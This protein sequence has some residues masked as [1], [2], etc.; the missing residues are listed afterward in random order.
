MLG[1][2][3]APACPA[4][5]CP[6]QPHH[7]EALPPAC[8]HT[9]CIRRSRRSLRQARQPLRE[10]V[11]RSIRQ[12]TLRDNGKPG[13]TR[14]RKAT[15]L[16]RRPATWQPGCR[17]EGVSLPELRLRRR[18]A[19]CTDGVPGQRA[20]DDA[21]HPTQAPRHP[22]QRLGAGRPTTGGWGEVSVRVRLAL[23]FLAVSLLIPL[24]GV[25]AV[26][27]QY[28]ASQRAATAE[29]RH[30]AEPIAH[31]IA[32][33]AELTGGGQRQLYQDQQRLQQYLDDLQRDLH[34]HMEVIDPQQRILAAATPG[35][36]QDEDAAAARQDNDAEVAATIRDG[37]PRTF[38]ERDQEYPAG[39]LQVVIPLRSEQGGIVGAVVMEYTP[40]YRELLAAGAGTRRAIVAA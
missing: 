24:V 1:R 33:T 20:R 40:I 25:L 31:T 34:R 15:G 23:A 29:A 28:A 13:E 4:K 7:Q 27:E 17:T 12:V 19:G 22:P 37:Q 5:T 36:E 32:N 30:V 38:A 6:Q 14:G 26:R 21:G 16:P 11:E 18:H 39:T 8:S 3:Q 9:R 10:A 2:A 35:N